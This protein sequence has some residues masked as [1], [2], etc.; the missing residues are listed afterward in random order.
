MSHDTVN[1]IVLVGEKGEGDN[2][3]IGTDE[4]FSL[5]QVAEMF[6]GRVEMLPTTKTTRASAE[7]DSIKNS[8]ARMGTTTPSAR[9]Y[10]NI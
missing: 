9:L 3:G 5:L 6:G 10:Q 8:S 4:V 2:F 1:G 7:V